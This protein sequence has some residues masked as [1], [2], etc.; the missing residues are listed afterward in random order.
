VGFGTELLF[1]LML[2]LVVLGPKRMHSMPAKLGYL[3]RAKAEFGKASREIKS[4]VLA[5]LPRAPQDGKNS[6][7]RGE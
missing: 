7:G 6:S 2:G 3:G 5:E 4:Q 1:L